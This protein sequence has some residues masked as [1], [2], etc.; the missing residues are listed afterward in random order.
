MTTTADSAAT[1]NLADNLVLK[2]MLTPEGRAD[3][4]PLY[5]ELRELA[6][7]HRSSMAPV[8][9][10]TRYEDCRAVLRDNRFGKNDNE[11]GS[12]DGAALFFGDASD[13]EVSDELRD[14]RSMLGLNPP[15]HTRL[16]GLVSRGFTPKRVEG[17]RPA[18]EAM[19]A[20]VLDGIG[21]GD[22][23]DVLS[24]LGFPLPVKVIGELVGVPPA[25][26]DQFRPLVRTAAASLEPGATKEQMLAAIDAMGELREY[27]IDLCAQRRLH[28]LDDLTSALIH[29]QDDED[30]LTE[31][32]VVSTLILIFAAGFETTTNLIGNGLLC[33]LQHADQLAR[34]RADRSLMP[35]A[36]EEMLRFQSPVQADGRR[37]LEN[38]DV[39]GVPVSEGEWAV[40]FLGAANR[41]PAVFD[42]PESFV[43]QERHTPVLS[44]ASG[45]HYCLG[46]SLARLEGQIVF[47]QL[48]DRFGTV[49]LLDGEPSWRNTL[50][51]RGLNELPVRVAV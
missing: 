39:A 36:I 50:I 1:Q 17:L 30:R 12:D 13:I 40:T 5:R 11:P 22:E 44:F 51:L 3:P 47:D 9:F 26:R 46:A 23:V 29:A 18:I 21:D 8:H 16:R 48:L 20:E 34:L 15:D 4:Y 24:V 19:T 2:I 14:N 45:I 42:D 37:A 33:L 25:D 43:I 41:D 28:S 32:E 10:L 6:P 49:E 38:A 7:I 35:A 27:F 31:N